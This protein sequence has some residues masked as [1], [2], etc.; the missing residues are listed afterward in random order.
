M[1]EKLKF[2]PTSELESVETQEERQTDI[3]LKDAPELVDEIGLLVCDI[4]LEQST[5][6]VINFDLLNTNVVTIVSDNGFVEIDEIADVVLSSAKAM[7]V[8]NILGT[9]VSS[10]EQKVMPILEVSHSDLI[11]ES[12]TLAKQDSEL[13]TRLAITNLVE[14]VL[15]DLT[16]SEREIQLPFF[17]EFINC[18]ERLPRSFSESSNSPFIV[19]VGE[20]KCEWHIPIIYALKELFREI[21]D[22]Y[23][24]ITFRDPEV[25]DEGMEELVDSL[26][27]HSLDRFG[28]EYKIEF[29][30]ARKM[31][32]AV[33]EFAKTVKGRLN[34]GF[35][36]Q[37]GVLVIAVKQKELEKTKKA[38]KA[39]GLRIYTCR[40]DN[41]NVKYERFCSKNIGLESLSDFFDGLKGYGKYLEDTNRKFSIF[42]KR[43]DGASDKLQYPLKVATFVY[44]LNDLKNRKKETIHNFKE[45]CE[46][47]KERAVLERE[48]KVECPICDGKVIPD[49]I[50]SPEGGVEK[51]ME[52][53]TLIGTF[54]PMKKVDETIEKYKDIP[55]AT[56][57]WVI[58][59][60][61][62]AILHYEELKSRKKAY[63]ILYDG[64]EIEFK[65]LSLVTSKKRFKWDLVDLDKFR[66][67]KKS[68]G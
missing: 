50:Y 47:L 48:L 16:A 45:L 55:E 44:L 68:V 4:L 49:L 1:K 11:L 5:P 39:E 62:S 56:T 42:V 18:D 63:K 27:P 2:P 36:Q 14:S 21:T 34:S 61:I 15:E 41:D 32:L 64:K 40:P 30:D 13:T 35:L 33:D 57:I 65:V 38:I 10:N 37:F 53:E 58:L 9:N 3:I 19:L 26:D 28:F 31:Y 59:K 52:I 23:P 46:F 54:E 6:S 67:V 29:L 8:S 17:E 12:K 22:R 24:K 25:W 60:P 43:G 51:Y 66:E 20:D 7:Q